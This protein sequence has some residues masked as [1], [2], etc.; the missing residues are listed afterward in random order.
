MV[1][2]CRE[3]SREVRSMVD[4][5]HTNV[6]WREFGR[7]VEDEANGSEGSIRILA[8]DGETT[9]FHTRSATAVG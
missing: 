1:N 2:I 7:E 6:K 4:Q 8:S 3:S 9:S 5:S